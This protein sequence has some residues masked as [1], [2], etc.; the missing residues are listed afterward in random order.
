MNVE[1]NLWHQSVVQ[2]RI[3]E[4][5]IISTGFEKKKVSGLLHLILVFN[6]MNTVQNS[7]IFL[8]MVVHDMR[9]PTSQIEFILQQSIE[10]LTSLKSY[11]N[12]LD[13]IFSL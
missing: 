5:Y 4:I 8:N 7:K 2:Q 9:N 10:S 1:H 3:L 6:L 12:D 11:M 13:K